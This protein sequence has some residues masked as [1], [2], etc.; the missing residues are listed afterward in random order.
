MSPT[1]NLAGIMVQPCAFCS[2]DAGGGIV[3]N[4]SSGLTTW[5]M[6][7]TLTCVY[8]LVV[9]ME[10]WPNSACNTTRSTPASSR[11]VAKQ[12]RSVWGVQGLVNPAS[13]P[14]CRLLTLAADPRRLGAQVGI[15]AILHTWGQNLLFHPHLHCVVL[16]G[17]QH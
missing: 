3:G 8:R 2:A 13:R 5:W 10:R 17:I 12:W 4:K 15:T 14:A 1:S 6:R 9:L 16:L 11:C 7:W